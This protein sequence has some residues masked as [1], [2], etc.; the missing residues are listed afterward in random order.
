M[1]D[2]NVHEAINEAIYTVTLIDEGEPCRFKLEVLALLVPYN[3]YCYLYRTIVVATTY[4]A[5]LQRRVLEYPTFRPWASCCL[6]LV[7][8]CYLLLA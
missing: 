4:H 6:F 8:P 2:G 3:G 5:Q 7:P 1:A